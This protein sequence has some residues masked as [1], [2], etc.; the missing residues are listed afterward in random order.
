MNIRNR[1]HRIQQTRIGFLTRTKQK[2]KKR[3]WK[4]QIRPQHSALDSIKATVKVLTRLPQFELF[5]S[6]KRIYFISTYSF[7]TQLQKEKKREPSKE[8]S[9]RT[10]WRNVIFGKYGNV[11]PSFKMT[12][13]G[14]ARQHAGQCNRRTPSARDYFLLASRVAPHAATRWRGEQATL[15]RFRNRNVQTTSDN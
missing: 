12:G 4:L 14:Q 3:I 15:I 2:T 7:P 1:R 10:F 13:R 6:K 11:G 8:S 5:G 9:E